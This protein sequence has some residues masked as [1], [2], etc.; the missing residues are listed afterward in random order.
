MLLIDFK[1]DSYLRE[2]V[3]FILFVIEEKQFKIF[4]EKYLKDFFLLDKLF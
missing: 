1:R 4:N 2:I 3:I